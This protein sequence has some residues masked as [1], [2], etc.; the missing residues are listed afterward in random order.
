MNSGRVPA[1]RPVQ[2]PGALP[3]RSDLIAP[4]PA[5]SGW[6]GDGAV[7]DVGRRCTGLES[8]AWKTLPPHPKL[9]PVSP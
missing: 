3:L 7:L 1:A 4:S 9:P 5:L 8:P 6:T 2:R